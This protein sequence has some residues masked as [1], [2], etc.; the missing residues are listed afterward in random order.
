MSMHVGAK[1]SHQALRTSQRRVSAHYDDM[2]RIVD[3]SPPNGVDGA[4]VE[5]EAAMQSAEIVRQTSVELFKLAT[6]MK[7]TGLRGEGDDE[8]FGGSGRESSCYD[9][10]SVQD[11]VVEG[12]LLESMKIYSKAEGLTSAHAAVLLEKFGRNELEEKTVP[13]WRV[14]A[15]QLVEPMPILIW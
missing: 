15:V 6:A 8:E 7:V 13:S 5:K 1:D 9:R 12:E 4:D 2:G 14:F 3:I 10:D 11:E